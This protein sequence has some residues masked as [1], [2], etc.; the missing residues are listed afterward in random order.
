MDY[1][2][3]EFHSASVRFS[4][5][6]PNEISTWI[7]DAVKRENRELLSLSVVFCSDDYLLSINQN[8]LGHF[9]YT[10]VITFDLSE[11]SQISGE[12]YIS[13]D[14][15]RENALKFA[16]PFTDELHR[17]IIHGVMHLC[18]YTDDNPEAKRRMTEKEDYYL[19]L[20]TF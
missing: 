5:D 1:N 8:Y 18:G 20:R 15:I 6:N 14:R 19:S 16:V 2:G 7:R 11:D 3:V 9:D 4:P 12:V 17:V 10:D 13:I